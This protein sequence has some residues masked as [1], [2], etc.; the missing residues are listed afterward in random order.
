MLLTVDVGNTN[1]HLGAYAGTGDHARLVR[2][3]RIHTDPHYTADELAWVF[4]GMLGSDI[5]QVTG[6]SALSTVPSLLRELRLMLPRYFGDGPHVLLEPGVRT[7][8]PLLVDN[9]KEVGTDRVS[10]C[11]AAHHE[12]GGPCIV[13]AFGTATVVD[14]VS[15]KG[16]FLGGAIA[17]GVNLA[18][19]ALSEHTVTVRKVEL[20]PPRSVLGKNT[21]EALQSG[22]LYGFAGQVDALV[23]RVCDTVPGF[24]G[25]DVT[26]VATG[27][28]APLMFDE[29]R[30]LTDHHPH[31]TLEGL[32]LVHE[33]SKANP[34]RGK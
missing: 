17:P 8:V 14:A 25:D 30:S 34:R 27:Y 4:R 31:L 2:D 3:W 9:P 26:V 11:L 23:D 20:M 6:V 16:E 24:D 13:V 15:A 10:N 1:I 33:R 19:E 28:L 5:E 12:Y 29:C 7:G 22:I 32:R 18:V 21:V